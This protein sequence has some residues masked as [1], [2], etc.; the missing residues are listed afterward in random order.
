LAI[1]TAVG[2]TWA[3]VE[4]IVPPSAV[5]TTP[6]TY[7]AV[8][9]ACLLSLAVTHSLM[10]ARTRWAGNQ[11]VLELQERKAVEQRLRDLIDHAPFGAFLCELLGKRHLRVTHTN[12]KA[13]IVLGRDASRLVGGDLIDVF[14]TAASRGLADQFLRVA[15]RG[16]TLDA[17]EV[18]VFSNGTRR[19]LEIHAYQTE[20]GVIAVFFSDVTQARI[21]EAEIRQ[22]AFHDEL[23]KL[24]NRKLLLDRLKVAIEG[25]RRRERG[26]GLLF[27]DLD[28]FKSLNDQYGHAFGDLVLAAVA[29]RL[30]SVARAS[31]T[32]ARIGGD[33]FTVLMPD[34]TGRDQV[35]VVACKLV[36][37]FQEPFEVDGR[38]I[39][40]T[41]SIGV[42]LSTQDDA[43]PDLLLQRADSAMYGT[44]RAGRNG[45]SFG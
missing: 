11:V 10:A 2:F 18:S 40:I 5:A 39:T 23:T 34:I 9:T 13:S 20:P 28:K 19:T 26:V 37:A 42:S 27:I 44:K 21:A 33:E 24:P 31:D 4:G 43:G 30:E 36:A 1:L 8:V 6:V 7:G 29:R 15:V 16:D 17:A 32:V 22:M 41:A 25:A 12:R 38:T 14:A 35:H 3:H 45:Y